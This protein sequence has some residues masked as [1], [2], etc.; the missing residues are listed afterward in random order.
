ME[1]EQILIQLRSLNQVSKTLIRCKSQEEAI[2]VALQEVR[3]KLNVQVASIFLF[4]KDGVL[5][6]FGID[7]VD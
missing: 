3:E 4:S 6:R 2:Q 1:R 5:K 7:G